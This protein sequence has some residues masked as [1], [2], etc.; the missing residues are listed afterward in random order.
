MQRQEAVERNNEK[1]VKRE[2]SPT[3]EHR[4]KTKE[5]PP[6]EGGMNYPPHPNFHSNKSVPRHNPPRSAFKQKKSTKNLAREDPRP[7]KLSN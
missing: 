3:K 5:T 6:R 2:D 1:K 4:D 7:S